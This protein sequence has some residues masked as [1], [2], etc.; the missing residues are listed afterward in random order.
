MV[1]RLSGQKGLD[2]LAPVLEALLRQR[3]QL[4]VLGTG[5]EHYHQLLRGVE[6]AHAEKVKAFLTFN[7]PLAQRIY[8]GSDLFLM[9]SR[10]EP[11]GL[12]QMIAMRYGSVPIVRAT[13][14][15][16][17]TVQDWDPVTGEGNGFRFG[18][19]DGL[20]LFA[21]IIRALETYRYPQRWQQLQRRG[22]QG[23]FSWQRSAGKYLQV[24]DLAL[25]SKERAA[26]V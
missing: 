18:R 22:M 10:Y 3:V 16:A 17:D 15:L 12:G 5:D 20:D 21:A 7:T 24:Y 8:G 19:Y 1:G 14:G 13:G 6:Q 2:I 9:P 11:C 23:D 26:V 4:V 25:R